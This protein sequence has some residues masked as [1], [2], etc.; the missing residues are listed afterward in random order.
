MKYYAVKVGEK[1]GVYTDWESCKAQV[2][3]YKGAQYKSFK[4]MEEAAAFVTGD[5]VNEQQAQPAVLVVDPP[6]CR[7]TA[8][9]TPESFRKE[10]EG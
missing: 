9:S 1:P 6:F 4:S 2:E 3:G 10:S 5:K 7:P 8:G